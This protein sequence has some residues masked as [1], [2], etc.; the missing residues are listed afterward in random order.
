MMT[1]QVRSGK[2]W[3]LGWHP[4]ADQFKGLVA[5]DTWAIE[6]TANEFKDFIRLAQQLS[7]TM[8]AMTEQLMDE[9]KLSCEQETETIWIEAE[10]FPRCYSLRFMLLTGRRGEGEWPNTVV[11][12]LL[13]ALNQ[14]P[15]SQINQ[16]DQI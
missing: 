13:E 16:I 15:F 5:G 7:T 1:R 9:E 2:G 12:K 10:G 6:L 3:R 4:H 8:T 11:P 14:S